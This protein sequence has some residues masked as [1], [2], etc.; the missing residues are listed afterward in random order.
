MTDYVWGKREG[1]LAS[2]KADIKKFTNKKNTALGFYVELKEVDNIL[3][4][5]FVVTF[6]GPKLRNGKPVNAN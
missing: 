1:T 3:K 2:L 6:K 4:D 5:Y